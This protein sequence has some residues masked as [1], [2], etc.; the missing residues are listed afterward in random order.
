MA[1]TPDVLRNRVRSLVVAAPFSY[2]EAVSSDDF[3]LQGSGSSDAVFRCV[4]SGGTSIG[5]FGYTEDR[6]DVLELEVARHIAADYMATF[7]TLVG[8][9]NSLLAAIVRDGHQTSGL[10]TVPDDGRDWAIAAP[11]GASYLTLRMTVPL[12][13]EAQV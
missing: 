8:D 2:R 11:V 6:T 4:V 13:Y 7:Q 10:Y 1:T 9:C 5:G 12:N 3:S